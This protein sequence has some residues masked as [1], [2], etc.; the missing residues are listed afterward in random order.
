[1]FNEDEDW[2][3]EQ[4]AQVVN[5]T[6][7]KTTQKATSSTNVKVNV[8]SGQWPAAAAA[9]VHTTPVME[10]VLWLVSLVEGN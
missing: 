1:M 5:K 9:R 7:L 6:V 10:D 3:D 8:L 2:N 4:D